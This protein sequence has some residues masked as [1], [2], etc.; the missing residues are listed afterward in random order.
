MSA[1]MSTVVTARKGG[2]TMRSVAMVISL[3]VLL[4]VPATAL[5]NPNVGKTFCL[6]QCR[7]RNGSGQTR[8]INWLKDKPTCT[9]SNA[10]DCTIENPPAKGG[11]LAG[12]LEGCTACTVA[13]DGTCGGRTLGI[14]SG[15]GTTSGV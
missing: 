5:D 8:A 4:T 6:C 3:V 7:A 1:G 13:E 15:V 14:T 2:W 10:K 9:E 12:S 11:N